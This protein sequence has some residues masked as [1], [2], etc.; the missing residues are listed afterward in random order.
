MAGSLLPGDGE[1][2]VE[3][4]HPEHALQASPHLGGG[5]G[6]AADEIGRYPGRPSGKSSAKGRFHERRRAGE[7]ADVDTIVERKEGEDRAAAGA[8]AQFVDTAALVHHEAEALSLEPK[9]GA[10]VQWRLPVYFRQ[11]RID[12]RRNRRWSRERR[13]GRLDVDSSMR[14]RSEAAYSE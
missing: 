3:V 5:V 10:G 13:V 2:V 6:L 11:L 7:L 9:L 12:R 14:T 8:G 4:G 1:Q